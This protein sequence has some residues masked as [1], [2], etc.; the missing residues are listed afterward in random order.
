MHSFLIGFWLPGWI[1]SYLWRGGIYRGHYHIM[2]VSAVLD[3]CGWSLKCLVFDCEV[4]PVNA[5]VLCEENVFLQRIYHLFGPLIDW[6][7]GLV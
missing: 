1:C 4:V 3:N 7:F 5:Q 2:K 6:E